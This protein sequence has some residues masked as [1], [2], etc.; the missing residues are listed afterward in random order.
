MRFGW[1][2]DVLLGDDL[3]GGYLITMRIDPRSEQI[4]MLDE[5]SEF[6]SQNGYGDFLIKSNNY[7]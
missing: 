2:T 6:L 3:F 5:S 1:C 4:L 7:K